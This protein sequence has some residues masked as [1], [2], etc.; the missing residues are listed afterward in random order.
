MK[1]PKSPLCGVPRDAWALI[2]KLIDGAG[3]DDSTSQP[4]LMLCLTAGAA[5]GVEVDIAGKRLVPR[6][7][8]GGGRPR[9]VRGRE[10]LRARLRLHL[11][12]AFYCPR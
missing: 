6:R 1:E 8:L 2:E 12:V 10:A 9:S 4:T 11:D 7:S 5:G 3:L